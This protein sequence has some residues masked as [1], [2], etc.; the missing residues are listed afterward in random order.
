[1]SQFVLL[2]MSFAPQVMMY[3]RLGQILNAVMQQ[4]HRLLTDTC[5]LG[6][7]ARV[8]RVL[9]LRVVK[10]F[11]GFSQNVR[12]PEGTSLGFLMESRRIPKG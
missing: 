8:A 4:H 3:S 12:G 9:A 6:W 10:D 5:T 11:C 1:M 7:L 2:A